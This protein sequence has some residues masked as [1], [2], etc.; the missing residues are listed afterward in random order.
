MLSRLI[1]VGPGF[2]T[3]LSGVM[4]SVGMAAIT[5]VVFTAK[6]LPNSNVLLI[7]GVIALTAG[8]CWFIL[9][10]QLQGLRDR[11]GRLVGIGTKA[12]DA[13]EQVLNGRKGFLYLVSL[14]ALACSFGWMFVG[15]LI[16][17]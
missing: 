17:C 8:L 6:K 2:F 3:F 15:S 13:F 7:S 4:V 10:E 11:F 9:G 16:G 12:E 5:Q 1:A 14:V